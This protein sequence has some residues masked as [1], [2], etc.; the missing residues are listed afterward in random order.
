MSLLFCMSR[1]ITATAFAH[2]SGVVKM[3]IV[4]GSYVTLVSAVFF[5]DFGHDVVR[6][7]QGQPKIKAL[8]NGE[9]SMKLEREL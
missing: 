9:T 3:V 6:V 8:H 7:K 4:G 1:D 5:A 2:R